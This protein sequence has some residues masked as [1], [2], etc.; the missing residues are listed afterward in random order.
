MELTELLADAM[1]DQ[2]LS[3]EALAYET[4]IRVPRIKAFVEDGAAGPIH[5]TSEELAELAQVLSL[6]LPDVVAASQ[7]HRSVSPA[8]HPV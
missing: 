6:P 4:G 2:H 8:G 7:D 5:P 1:R 3:T